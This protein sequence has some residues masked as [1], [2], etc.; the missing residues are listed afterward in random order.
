MTTPAVTPWRPALT[1]MQTTTPALI[2]CRPAATIMHQTAL[3]N[4]VRAM[5]VSEWQACGRA[6]A[7]AVSL[8]KQLARNCCD[9][10]PLAPWLD[11]AAACMRLVRNPAT[12][13][14]TRLNAA[15]FLK[16]FVY[17]S[18]AYAT[19]CV[20]EG[21]MKELCGIM[22]TCIPNAALMS[23]VCCIIACIARCTTPTPAPALATCD[24]L[25]MLGAMQRLP[26]DSHSAMFNCM[27]AIRRVFASQCDLL[28]CRYLRIKTQQMVVAYSSTYMSKRHVQSEAL[29]IMRVI[30]KHT[31]HTAGFELDCGMLEQLS[32]IASFHYADYGISTLACDAAVA[33]A[34]KHNTDAASVLVFSRIPACIAKAHFRR[35]YELAA[36]DAV[37]VTI[38][39]TA[40]YSNAVS[41]KLRANAAMGRLLHHL[42]PQHDPAAGYDTRVQYR[43]LVHLL[44]GLH[45]SPG[46]VD[47]AYSVLL[48]A[49]PVS[50][51]TTV[52]MHTDTVHT[53]TV[54]T[55]TVYINQCILIRHSPRTS[56]ATANNIIENTPNQNTPTQ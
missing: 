37:P 3:D 14:S 44:S 34:D 26:P 55:D 17:K 42:L 10:D 27:R 39:A 21:L 36:V 50:V 35:T 56:F 25:C 20:G 13:S 5:D 15:Q 52:Y 51:N 22:H 33:C 23:N 40:A 49:A 28:T 31:Q 12:H 43:A 1:S 29:K 46:E 47:A 38:P 41:L 8:L 6:T 19:L 7:D 30:Y 11:A 45:C 53:D 2:V 16:M 18:N 4:V 32:L 9:F 48:S 24:I 54:H